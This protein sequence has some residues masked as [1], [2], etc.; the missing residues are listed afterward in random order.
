M[1][2]IIKAYHQY[3]NEKITGSAINHRKRS[4]QHRH[5]GGGA[6]RAR[7]VVLAA[8]QSYGGGHLSCI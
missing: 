2:G 1:V 7:M 5:G 3:L 8:Y 6:H 4:H